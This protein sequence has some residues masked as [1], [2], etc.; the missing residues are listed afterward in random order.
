MTMTTSLRRVCSILCGV[1]WGCACASA[2]AEAILYGVTTG[3][4]LVRFNASAPGTILATTSITG[5]QSGETVL[6]IDF[7]PANGALHALGSTSRLYTLSTVTGVATQ[8]GAA[9]AF[10]LS[11]VEFGMDFNPLV[12]RIRVTS[13][14][15]QN[16]RLNPANGTL[17]AT[18]TPLAYAGGG[19][20]AGVV[21]SAY[22]NNLPGATTTTLYDI[23]SNL[24]TLV[25][26][27]PPNGGTLTAVGPLGV[28]STGVAGFDIRTVAG[29]NTAYA[30]LVV[31][32]VSR[33][34]IVNLNTGAATLVGTIGGSAVRGLA[35]S[36]A[37]G[38]A[39]DFAAIGRAGI[40]WRDAGSGALA[41]WLMNGNAIAA[42]GFFDLPP[43]WI[44]AGT[45]D[46]N[47]DGSADILWRRGAT[48][49]TAIWFMQGTQRSA[50]A[51]FSVPADWSVAAVGDVNG[52]GRAD[53]VWRRPAN[54]D[55]AL[56][57]MNGASAT[58]TAFFNVPTNWTLEAAADLNGD[59]AADFLW[60]DH[61]S[62]AL[63]LWFMNGPVH[64]STTFFVV[65]AEWT[66]AGTGDFDGDGKADI[67][68]RRP[69]TGDLALWF[70]NGGTL[71][72]TAFY[73]VPSEWVLMNAGDFDG[74]GRDDLLWRNGATNDLAVWFMDGSVVASTAFFGVPA[75]WTV[76]AP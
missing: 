28:D 35:V 75:N 64:T 47:G 69:A 52:D 7:R 59:H 65:P 11:G 53:I 37:R 63:A 45:G 21:G 60:R 14:I 4:S 5:L 32:G 10:T 70:M 51:F 61:A 74:N 9:G 40:A 8:V 46:F 76:V 31:G 16:L 33:L 57:F 73:N 27:N 44:L 54:G 71:S 2:C 72:A 42:T 68:W 6:A 49:E 50:S 36:P 29:V 24:D 30:S 41:L 1:L 15:G 22:T 43:D 3:N 23:D 48:G 20:V 56:W 17:S 66:V 18:D 25:V 19:V 67:A 26:Q 55:V 12:D 58:A 39:T 62:G 13:D 34:F 38:L